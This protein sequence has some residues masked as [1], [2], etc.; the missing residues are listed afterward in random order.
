M[1]NTADWHNRY[2]QTEL[3]KRGIP[4]VVVGGFKF[5]ERMH[6]KDIVA[7]L[8]LTYNPSDA[9][10]WHRVLKYIGGIGQLTATK[11]VA[12]LQGLD[13]PFSF[14]AFKARRFYRELFH[15][16]KLLLFLSPCR[17]QKILF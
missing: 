12:E 6:V 4:Y 17:K 7:Y 11:V 16:Q 3:S 10:S 1:L 9:V 14:E 13:N 5:S 8:K 2:I 15:V